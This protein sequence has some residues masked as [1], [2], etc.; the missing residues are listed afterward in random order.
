MSFKDRIDEMVLDLLEGKKVTVEDEGEKVECPKCEGK[1]CDH[2]DDKGYHMAEAKANLKGS[3]LVTKASQMPGGK[4]LI[5]RWLTG[6]VGIKSGEMHK[7]SIDFDGADLVHNGKTVVSKA[8][9][10]KKMKLDDLLAALKKGMGMKEALDPVGKEDDDVDNDGDV[11]S[12]DKYLKK[13]RAAIS[14]AVKKEDKKQFMYAAKMAKE[15]GDEK[16]MFAGKEYK[17]E[18]ADLVDEDSC[19][20]V[21]ASKI[22]K[23]G[24]EIRASK[25]Y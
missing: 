24:K 21:S 7:N 8:L 19:G 5:T 12:S 9:T 23:M 4:V 25:K 22:K 13:R 18:D 1:G 6:E 11:D 16:F 15:K 10:N 20:T 3:D 17:V 2:C 14:K